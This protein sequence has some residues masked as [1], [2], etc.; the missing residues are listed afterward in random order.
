MEKELNWES[1][2]EVVYH[3]INEYPMAAAFE[4]AVDEMLQN[5]PYNI[6]KVWIKENDE[7]DF[8]MS[9]LE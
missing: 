7:R 8:V 5:S 9:S 1:S 6:L 2:K 3:A 4:D